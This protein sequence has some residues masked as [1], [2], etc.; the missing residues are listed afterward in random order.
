MKEISLILIWYTRKML[1]K[2]KIKTLLTMINS[3]ISFTVWWKKKIRKSK[4]LNLNLNQNLK[5]LSNNHQ[6]NSSSLWTNFLKTYSS[7]S[8]TYQSSRSN[9]FNSKRSLPKR[10]LSLLL[11]KMFRICLLTYQL[12]LMKSIELRWTR[13]L[14]W[15]LRSI[16][17]IY[18][19]LW[20]LLLIPSQS[21]WSKKVNN[22]KVLN[23]LMITIRI[24]C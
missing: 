16:K 9:K 1:S 10:N 18:S 8:R 15:N 4:S 21:T 7:R 20:W 19:N 12:W 11:Y 13:L 2:R 17:A 23:K 24:G 3:R 14:K 22:N 5:L 6:L